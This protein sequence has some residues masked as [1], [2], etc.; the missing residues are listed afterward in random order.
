MER[1]PIPKTFSDFS[2]WAGMSV[3]V[4][5]HDSGLYPKAFTGVVER[6]YPRYALVRTT[7]GY[8]ATIHITDLVCRFATVRPAGSVSAVHS[9]PRPAA[10]RLAVNW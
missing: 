6:L 1:M 4:R 8:Y 3:T 7:T 5:H 10:A 2:I 9:G